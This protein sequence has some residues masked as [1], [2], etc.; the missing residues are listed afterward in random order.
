VSREEIEWQW[1]LR[2]PRHGHTLSVSAHH[3][4]WTSCSFESG[5]GRS[6]EEAASCTLTERCKTPGISVWGGPMFPCHRQWEPVPV[7]AGNSS[8]GRA[9]TL[10]KYL[11]SSAVG[12]KKR[13]R[14]RGV[15]GL[16]GG[17]RS[18]QL[19]FLFFKWCAVKPY[20]AYRGMEEEDQVSC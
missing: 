4:Q 2:L 17:Y 8:R 18:G 6:G 12:R 20:Q 7:T 19:L 9:H 10:P 1:L 16:W 3:L 15:T 5:N 11:W 14:E 13:G